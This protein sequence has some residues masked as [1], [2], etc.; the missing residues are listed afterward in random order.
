[1]PPAVP[2]VLV[3]DDERAI[4][5]AYAGH[6]RDDYAVRVAYSGEAALEQVDDTVDVVLLDRRMPDLSG[7]A[8]L[9][10]IRNRGF[11]C[12][13]AMI[14]AVEPDVDV[15][16]ME[17]D[18][19]LYKPVSKAE[20]RD[21]VAS[22]VTRTSYDEQLQEYFTLI[23]KRATLEA[24]R[25]GDDL[26]ASDAFTELSDRIEA[27]EADVDAAATDL[28]MDE[29]FATALSDRHLDRIESDR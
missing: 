20:L 22:L 10:R 8:V 9:E 12:H 18:D 29:V 3:V 17:F 11:T 5:D 7:D 2:T 26:A 27:L 23:S 25:S 16:E 21:A 13:V 19:Y 15:I 14:T 1:M 6:L 28:A 4:A 24:N